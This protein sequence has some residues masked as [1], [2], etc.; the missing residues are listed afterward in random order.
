M[1]WNKTLV[2]E[3]IQK[4]IL[5]DVGMGDITTDNLITSDQWSKGY[6]LAKEDGIIAGLNVMQMVFNKFDR[7]M[8]FKLL[9]KDGDEIKAGDK[10]AELKGPTV[11][12]LKG[13]RVALN[14]LQRLSAIATKTHH[15]VNLVKDF[16]TRIADTRKTTPTLRILEKYAVTVGGGSNHRMGLYDAVMIKDNHIVALGSISKAIETV[17]SKIPHTVKIEVEVENFDQVKEAV[18]SKVD[19]IML[20]N[21][22]TKDMLK[23]VSYING[24]TIV[25]ASGGINE[26][27]IREVATTGVDVISI[28]DLTTHIESLDIG[29]DLKNILQ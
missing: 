1:Y 17:R 14:F 20:D 18:E 5:E 21:M 4:A 12:I 25:E 16:P 8:K 29:L 26:K 3:I 10:I 28:G 27:N 9:F 24:K 19:V 22:S 6:I 7:N 2:N 15:Y 23:S 11:A 13:E